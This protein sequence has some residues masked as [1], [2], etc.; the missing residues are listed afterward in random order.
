M[1]ARYIIV[2]VKKFTAQKVPDDDESVIRGDALREA[3]NFNTEDT[4]IPKIEKTSPLTAD[5]LENFYHKIPDLRKGLLDIEKSKDGLEG[6]EL[7]NVAEKIFQLDAGIKFI[8]EYFSEAIHKKA[9]LPIPIARGLFTTEQKLLYSPVLYGFSFGDRIWGAFSVLRLKEVQWKPE[10]IE[11]LSIP[12]VN[13]D[14]LRSVVQA[15]ATKQDNFDDIVQDKG[16]SLI[17]LFTGPLNV[18]KTLTAEVMAEIAE[19]PLYML[20]SGE[21]N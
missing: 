21:V 2:I 15:N 18:G 6:Q 10:I 12:P 9:G 17:G 20:S 5:Q 13:K 1:F 3:P 11:F 19:R 4:I 8:T 16:K 14:F 7:D